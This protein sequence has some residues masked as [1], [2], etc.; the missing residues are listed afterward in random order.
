MM[1]PMRTPA[2]PAAIASEAVRRLRREADQGVARQAA[3]YFK[4]SDT[5]AA[6]G[7][8]APAIR[9]IARDLHAQVAAIWEVDQALAC[10]DILS[11]RRQHEAK[12][13][14]VLLLGRYRDRF[15]STLLRT[16]RTWIL[17]GR[18]PNWAGIDLV[19]PE[20]V[21]PLVAR[22]P[23]VAQEVRRWARNR[24]LWLRRAAVVAFVTLARSGDHLDDAYG[25][26][27]DLLADPEDLI[28][29]ACGWLLR[30]AGKTNPRRLERFLLAHG[31][32]VPRTTVRYAIER[33]PLAARRRLLVATRAP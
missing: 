9:A 5:F 7:V 28:H 19:S 25:V 26:V 14:G 3:T 32:A 22:T 31:A 2:T 11:A 12:A 33:F 27:E 15:P 6:W 16:V 21:T 18:F 4:R 29:K 23:G 8:R 30:E 13:V 24:S 17:E 10:C 20:L 1:P